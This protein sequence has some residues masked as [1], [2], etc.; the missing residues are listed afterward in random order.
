MPDLDLESPP[1]PMRYRQFRHRQTG[2]YFAG[3]L[4]VSP[5]RVEPGV[6]SVPAATHCQNVADLHGVHVEDVECVEGEGAPPALPAHARAVPPPPPTPREAAL[7]RIRA[8]PRTRAVIVADL[9]DL[10]AGLGL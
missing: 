6:F 2:E 10:L 7:A 1:P 5:G 3:T 9:H 4:T 8:L